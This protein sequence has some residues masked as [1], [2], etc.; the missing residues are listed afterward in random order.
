MA[1]LTTTTA[2][3]NDDDGVPTSGRQAVHYSS[4]SQSMHR[5]PSQQRRPSQRALRR[6]LVSRA[7]TGP[8]PPLL[9]LELPTLARQPPPPHLRSTR[10]KQLRSRMHPARACARGVR[11]SRPSTSTRTASG[12]R[13]T[14]GRCAVGREPPSIPLRPPP[15]PP[16]LRPWK[17][18]SPQLRLRAPQPPDPSTHPTSPDSGSTPEPS[19]RQRRAPLR[20]QPPLPQPRPHLPSRYRTGGKPSR[21]KPTTTPS[22]SSSPCRF[23]S[24]SSSRSAS[25]SASLCDARNGGGGKRPPRERREGSPPP[26]EPPRPTS[27]GRTR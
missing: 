15:R 9:Q 22:R 19:R 10:L 4:H 2:G 26:T 21:A 3:D 20:L 7:I 24:P 16:T 23:S 14:A 13:T 8:R 25:L 5:H 6:R 27:T 11:I 17:T 1:T 18:T 12:S